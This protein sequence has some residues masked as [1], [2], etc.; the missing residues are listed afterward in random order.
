MEQQKLLKE[1]EKR[2]REEEDRRLDEKLVRERLEIARRNNQELKV[3][4]MKD[5]D[6]AVVASADK[7]GSKASKASEA[8]P[9]MKPSKPAPSPTADE[10]HHQPLSAL[11]KAKAHIKAA[12]LAAETNSEREHPKIA[13][14]APSHQ[15][16]SV[17]PSSSPPMTIEALQQQSQILQ[18]Q[19]QFQKQISQQYQQLLQLAASPAVQVAQQRAA[20]GINP[21][22]P[23]GIHQFAHHPHHFQS[24]PQSGHNLPPQFQPP[25]FQ[26]NVQANSNYIPLSNHF[27]SYQTGS[28]LHSQHHNPHAQNFY[29][30]QLQQQMAHVKSS[31]LP[32][33][34]LLHHQAKLPPTLPFSPQEIVNKQSPTVEDMVLS[35]IHSPGDDEDDSEE[36]DALQS[37]YDGSIYVPAASRALTGFA[38]GATAGKSEFVPSE[39]LEL[40]DD[41]S[42]KQDD[43]P[44]SEE[45]PLSHVNLVVRTNSARPS[46]SS[47]SVAP[48]SPSRGTVRNQKQASAPVKKSEARRSQKVPRAGGGYKVPTA[49]PVSLP[50]LARP[51]TYGNFDNSASKRGDIS[52]PQSARPSSLRQVSTANSVTAKIRSDIGFFSFINLD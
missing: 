19:L 25:P 31:V 51:K 46:R 28:P 40:Q 43:E 15:Q 27:P 23:A 4:D 44:E 6:P 34:V 50:Q 16:L 3:S 47:K 30:Q 42:P 26:P 22:P 18:Q 1:E 12:Q 20:L 45:L 29:L 35:N 13:V 36:L 48:R 11:A 5:V 8:S 10:D 39:H 33:P 52:I 14:V 37:A 32:P 7:S 17:L 38:A 49:P 21:Y 41:P 2:R 9:N 24:M